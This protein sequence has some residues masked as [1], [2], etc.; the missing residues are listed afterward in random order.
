MTFISNHEANQGWKLRALK[1]FTPCTFLQR[2]AGDGPVIT[3]YLPEPAAANDTHI[4]V[5][6]GE[7][8]LMV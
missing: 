5:E 6:R 7:S 4:P 2:I 8:V 3:A 1:G